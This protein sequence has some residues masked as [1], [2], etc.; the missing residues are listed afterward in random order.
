[1]HDGLA[2]VL[3]GSV[4]VRAFNPWPGCHATFMLESNDADKRGLNEAGTNKG[5]SQEAFPEM[6]GVAEKMK[7]RIIKTVV[8][9]KEDWKGQCIS[10]I[11][12]TK[13]A[14]HVMCNDGS[15][16]SILQVQ[17]AGKK[18]VSIQAFANGELQ[19]RR[20]HRAVSQHFDD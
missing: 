2:F 17:K 6:E 3:F 5:K 15:V 9:Q 4:Q 19:N 13:H 8:G 12:A 14:L 18:P 16:L 1:M 7:L 20:M 10:D 11:T